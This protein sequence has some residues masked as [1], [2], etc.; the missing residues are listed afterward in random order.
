[1]SSTFFF[2]QNKFNNKGRKKMGMTLKHAK[3]SQ[4]KLV[5]RLNKRKTK[6]KYGST[7]NCYCSKQYFLKGNVSASIDLYIKVIKQSSVEKFTTKSSC[8]SY[9]CVLTVKLHAVGCKLHRTPPM[10]A[11]SLG[12]LFEFC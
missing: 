9:S 3:K 11:T 10:F 2:L 8:L 1:M 7:Y 4:N 12:T 6:Q 5:S